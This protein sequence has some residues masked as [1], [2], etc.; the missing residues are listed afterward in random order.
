M[1]L[2][3]DVH[4]NPGP[5]R[6]QQ[7]ATRQQV[8]TTLR[9]L[10]CNVNGWR[11][12]QPALDQLLRTTNPDVVILQETRLTQRDKTPPTLGYT[13]HRQD[14]TVHRAGND[15]SQGG[16]ATLVREGLAHA[17]TPVPDAPQGALVERLAINIQPP[18]KTQEAVDI[19]N[20]YRPPVRTNNQQDHRDGGLHEELWP[21]GPSWL[22]MGDVNGHGAWDPNHDQD[23]VGRTIEDWLVDNTWIALNTGDPTRV[24]STGSGTAPDVSLAHARWSSRAAWTVGETIGSDHLPIVLD[25]D[26]GPPSKQARPPNRPNWKRGDWSRF[27]TQ[28]ARLFEDWSAAHFRSAAEANQ[29]F[30][31]KIH[32]AS[33]GCI[34][35]GSVPRVHS[36]W[37]EECDQA[38][39]ELRAAERH[40]RVNPGDAA[41]T[42]L[43]K[44]A[45]QHYREVLA[46]QKT[47]A[48]RK[49]TA[50]LDPTTPTSKVW[51]VIRALDGRAKRPLPDTPVTGQ[52]NRPVHEE[53]KKADL[54]ASTYAETSRVRIPRADAKEAYLAVRSHLRQPTDQED[55]LGSDF[56]YQELQS[57]LRR[58]GG[59]APGPDMVHPLQLRKLPPSGKRALLQII[60]PTWRDGWIPASW[61]RATIIPILKRGKGPENIKSYRPVSLTS[62]ISKIAETM[63]E[64]RMRR[65]AEREGHIPAS[66]S[67]FRRHRSTSDALNRLIQG[68]F[69]DLQRKP[70]RR[71][72]IVAVDFR[73]AFDS[74]WRGGLL[75]RLA[76]LNINH[77]WLRWVR[78]FLSDRRAQVKWNNSLSRWRIFK[79][80]LPQGTPLSPLLFLLFISSL[81]QAIRQA[82]PESSDTSFADDLTLRTADVDTTSAAV[83][84]Q[85]ALDAL[86]L[87]CQRHHLKLAP[88]KT[89][90]MLVTVDP[91][92]TNGKVSPPL[93][94]NNVPI[95]YVTSLKI[96]G[97]K[98]D[99]QLI[100]GEQAKTA[101][102]KIRHRNQVLTAIAARSWGADTDALR[103]IYLAY[104]RPAGAYAAGTWL[105]YASNTQVAHVERANNHAARI[106]TGAPAKT[107]TMAVVREAGLMPMKTVAALDGATQLL[108]YSR[109]APDHPLRLLCDGPTTRIKRQGGARSCWRDSSR[110]A[111]A[112]AGL[113]DIN[114]QPLPAPDSTPPPWAT[115]EISF[116][117]TGNTSREDPPVVRRAMAEELLDTLR[118][119]GRPLAEVWTDGAAVGG[120][121]DG[122][123][124]AVIKWADDRPST[125]VSIAAGRLTNSTAAEAAAL[126]AGLAEADRALQGNEQRGVIWALFDSRALFDRLQNPA[127]QDEDQ[128]TA[129]ASNLL[130]S[131]GRRHAVK[132]VWIPGHAGLR[133]NEEADEAARAGCSM[134]QEDVQVTAAAAKALLREKTEEAWTREYEREMT[135]HF[136][137]RATAGKA[138]PPYPGKCR[139]ADV[140]L[141]QL[142]L[143]R[144]TFLRDTQHRWGNVDSPACPHCPPPAPKEDAEHFLLGCGQWDHF[145][146]E[147]LRGATSLQDILQD[148]PERA[149]EFGARAGVYRPRYAQRR[150]Q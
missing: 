118:R 7:R 21:T 99:T 59:K 79:E 33:T 60:N 66:Q 19:L 96:L 91:R 62:C 104:G 23:E 16:L 109:F 73:A 139:Q 32:A 34:P 2:S 18:S 74:V 123:G 129:R 24:S 130:H 133:H 56:S 81:P 6:H 124:G 13:E 65:W 38:E 40:L 135:G 149:L 90:A 10:Q 78:S 136:H 45:R 12:R 128:Q 126:A 138:L 27:R 64:Q 147:V 48:W 68:A 111:L 55:P 110:R 44:A 31:T 144:G 41:A 88:E 57:A 4:P 112:D 98:V 63:L 92:Q 71:S 3:G 5:R 69:D 37:T 146:Q 86:H 80:G 116:H 1:T 105:P 94:I 115:S 54:A 143:N 125:V 120:V 8:R 131:L 20:I 119:E 47:A 148:H 36:W 141:H 132:V 42:E 114:L 113:E 137:W 14:R 46:E 52:D 67:G 122:G 102:E 108:H 82:A 100:M 103:R 76:D 95:T 150:D 15:Q 70:G 93:N 107:N 97:V 9:I 134:P 29:D 75:R 61:R 89:E 83:K 140:F 117:Q 72:I 58:S 22:I 26:I 127:R 50:T 106:I 43:H 11:T 101:A 87:W 85:R 39:R 49:F 35:Q 30:V 84:M 145:R 121:R 142:R 28:A 53:K 51:S 17:R 25:L 77:R